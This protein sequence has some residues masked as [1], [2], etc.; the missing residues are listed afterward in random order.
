MPWA[1]PQS[2][3]PLSR[4]VFM[5]NGALAIV[6]AAS[7]PSFLTRSVLA[8]TT[9]AQPRGK[10]LV[11][12][13]QRGA[14]DGLNVVVPHR[15]KTYY[16]LR[17]SI[18]IP[19]NQ[20]I[21]LDGF[22]G[23]HPALQPLMPLWRANHLAIV[24]ACGS[25]DP[26]RS[27]FDAQDFMESGTPGLRST[28]TGWLNRALVAEDAAD[29]CPCGGHPFRAV[30][31][32]PELPLT[33]QGSIPSIALDNVRA[34]SVGGSNPAVSPIAA[35]FQTMYAG[36][37]DTVLHGTAADTFQAVKMLKAADPGQ[38]VPSPG[39]NY[40]NGPFGQKMM[41]I[42]QLLK[43]NLG[44]EAAFADIGGWDT[45]QNQGSVNG[46]LAGRLHEFSQS[47]AAFW[48]D[49]GDDAENISLVTMSEFGRTVHENGTGGTDHGHAN[50]MF[51]LGGP[52]RGGKVY[53]K[54]PGMDKHQLYQDR[55]LAITTDFRQ[56]L[57]EAAYRTLGARNMEMVF[58][59]ANLQTS[60]FLNILQA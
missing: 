30:A 33:L 31:I 7:I 5:K 9:T 8:Q 22:F 59:G 41:Q 13:F 38:Y 45:H 15:E 11:V 3:L 54:W 6:G 29:S 53:G 2:H 18:A 24:H 16:D 52:V 27:H 43:A 37:V 44:V 50:V 42:A 10:K 12:I 46:Q 28:T 40:P 58:P 57:G 4:R 60:H 19:Q 55:D 1:K 47:L 48:T 32:E 21:D 49:L 56:V 39:A 17:P 51:V 35:G 36:S 20:V 26:T 25:P 14:A 23:L 34:F